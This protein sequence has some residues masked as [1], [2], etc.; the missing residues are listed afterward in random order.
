MIIVKTNLKS[1]FTLMEMMV[2][3][4][5]VSI[6]LISTIDVASRAF[7][8]KFKFD[9]IAKA[10]QEKVDITSRITSKIKE[11]SAVYT[12]SQTITIPANGSNVSVVGENETLAVLVPKFDSNGNVVQPTPGTTTLFTGI[13]FTII[14]AATWYNDNENHKYDGK[15]VLLETTADFNLGVSAADAL[16]VTGALPTSWSGGQT[17]LLADNL[18]PAVT[19]NL[20][21]IPFDVESDMVSFA[22]VPK[23]E[24]IYFPSA[25]GT[26]EIDDGP[27]LTSCTF[28]NYR[29]N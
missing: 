1:G 25:D 17:Y 24:H 13:A 27:N 14:P 23:G 19:D 28:R 22:F 16:K 8:A 15:Y 9:N 5:I 10:R 21:N 7:D 3:T 20:G 26:E 12:S 2:V 4:L 6:I 29:I 11:A 18:K